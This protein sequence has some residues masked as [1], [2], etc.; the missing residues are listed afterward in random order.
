MEK[1]SM[2]TKKTATSTKKSKKVD[3]NKPAAAGKVIAAR[4]WS[5]T[6]K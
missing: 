1:K 4:A 3:T 6:H 2:T 5:G